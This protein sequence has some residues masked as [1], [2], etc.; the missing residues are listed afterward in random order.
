MGPAQYIFSI[1]CGG[2]ETNIFKRLADM[3]CVSDSINDSW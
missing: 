2:G 1:F 3:G